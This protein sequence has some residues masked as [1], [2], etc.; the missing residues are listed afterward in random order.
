MFDGAKRGERENRTRHPRVRLGFQSSCV[1]RSHSLPEENS[2]VEPPARRLRGG[3]QSHLHDRVRALCGLPRNRTS[4]RG[5][6]VPTGTQ[7]AAHSGAVLPLNYPVSFRRQV[8]TRTR[9]FPFVERRGIEPRLTD[10]Q[11]VVF[12]L[13]ERP[14]SWSRRESNPRS[15]NANA[16]S[17]LWTT[18]PGPDLNPLAAASSGHRKE[19]L[20]GER[21]A[22]VDLERLELSADRLQSVPAPLRQGPWC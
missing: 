8:G 14:V 15:C 10:C 16:V 17:S 11:P 18:T 7:T 13:D 9:V 6:G 2:G 4:L 20:K 5:F 22:S 3:V 19:L 21:Q 12:P 1:T